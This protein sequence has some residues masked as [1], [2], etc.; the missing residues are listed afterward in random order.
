MHSLL[1]LAPQ[2][3]ALAAILLVMVPVPLIAF[4]L[5]RRRVGH[6]LLDGALAAFA[7]GLAVISPITIWTDEFMVGYLNQIV[8]HNPTS[9]TLRLFVIPVSILAFRIFQN[10]P[11]RSLNHRVY[12]LLLCAV[13]VILLI[14]AKPSFALALLPGCCF[15]AFWRT[16]RRGHVDWILLAFGVFLLAALMLGLQVMLSYVAIDN[17]TSIEFGF[18]TFM[19]LYLPT[20]R[21]PI[22]LLLSIVWIRAEKCW[23]RHTL[24]HRLQCSTICAH[25]LNC[26]VRD[27][28]GCTPAALATNTALPCSHPLRM[29]RI[30]RS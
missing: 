3:A 7:L 30:N 5:F 29:L 26:R 4:A 24:P 20:W 17:G 9:I 15:F 8:Y 2:D 23:R 27:G 16:L 1:G 22:Q 28:S 21:I 12:H 25:G 14:L 6:L 11:Y 19:K 18:L 10:R 13:L